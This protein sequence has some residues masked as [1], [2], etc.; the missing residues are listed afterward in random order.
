M[1]TMLLR[2]AQAVVA[3][4]VVTIPARDTVAMAADIAVLVGAVAGTVLAIALVLFIGK[5]RRTVDELRTQAHQNFGPVSDRARSIS[6]NVEF[7]TDALRTDVTRLNASLKSLTERLQLASDR[8]E[9][10]I[11]EFNAL[12]EVVQ[13]EAEDIFIDTA[14]TVRGVKESARS[15]TK[16]RRPLPGPEADPPPVPALEEARAPLVE[17]RSD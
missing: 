15:V 11:E 7:I 10:R 9:E 2:V 8:M 5:M 6:D 12:M 16:P 14:A 3:D 17:D 1:T 4:T 13:S